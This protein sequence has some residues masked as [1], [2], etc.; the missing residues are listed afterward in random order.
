MHSIGEVKERVNGGRKAF[1]VNRKVLQ[2]NIL[3]RRSKLEL[4]WSAIRPV[5]TYACKARVLKGNSAE[6]NEA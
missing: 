1:Y 2:C 5:V 4:Y 3:T 6:V